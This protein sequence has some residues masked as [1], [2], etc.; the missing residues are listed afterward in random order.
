[1]IVRIHD[2]AVTELDKFISPSM[3]KFA[4]SENGSSYATVDLTIRLMSILIDPTAIH[5]IFLDGSSLRVDV[6][7]TFYSTIEVI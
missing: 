6:N 7:P 2:L 1:M 4:K 3:D 5:I